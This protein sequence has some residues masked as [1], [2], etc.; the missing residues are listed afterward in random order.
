MRNDPALFEVVEACRYVGAYYVTLNWHN[1]Q[2]E[3]TPILL[4]SG[5]KVLVTHSDL[6]D[7][8]VE[9]LPAG[10]STLVIDTPQVILE[11]YAVNPIPDISAQHS[12]E[13]LRS[14]LK[15]SPTVEAQPLRFRGMFSY[16]SG[17]TGKIRSLELTLCIINWFC[18]PLRD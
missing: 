14:L 3:V 4:D 2:A 13:N 1:T 17:S 7:S 10:L 9:S 15:Q 6:L 5:A 18:L 12:S 16:T 11:R 8:F